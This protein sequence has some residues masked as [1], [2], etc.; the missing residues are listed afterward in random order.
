MEKKEKQ[1]RMKKDRRN[2][3]ESDRENGGEV[4][5][6]DAKIGKDEDR[7][8]GQEV[9]CEKML[10]ESQEGTEVYLILLRSPVSGVK[11]LA[12]DENQKVCN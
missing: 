6:V 8:E 7:R 11:F 2:R 4:R 5:I 9:E 12:S 1:R 3:K 10:K